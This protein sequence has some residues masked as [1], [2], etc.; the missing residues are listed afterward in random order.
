M[1]HNFHLAFSRIS[2]KERAN[3]LAFAEIW[4]KT[5][6]VIYKVDVNI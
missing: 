6:I 2:T 3:N 4:I 1:T 5:G